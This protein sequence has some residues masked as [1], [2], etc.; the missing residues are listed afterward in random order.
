MQYTRR[1][2]DTSAK[3]VGEMKDIEDTEACP[4]TGKMRIERDSTA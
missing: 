3:S 2:S 4:D 1:Y